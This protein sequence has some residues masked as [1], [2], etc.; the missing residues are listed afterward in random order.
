MSG[1]TAFLLI[2]ALVIV[3][4]WSTHAADQPSTPVTL[5]FVAWKADHP[6]AWEEAFARF[7]IQH[8]HISIVRELAPHSSTAYHDLLTQKLRNHDATVDLFFMDI[9]WVP[10]FAS[11]GW[12]MPLDDLFAPEEQRAFLPAAVETGRYNGQIYGVPSRIDSG[13][14]FYRTDLLAK[15]GFNPPVT[16]PELIGQATAIVQGEHAAHPALSGYSGQFK[17]YEGLVCSMMEFIGSAGGRLLST[18]LRMSL[19]S[20]PATL[21]AVGFV[22]QHIIGN[23]ASRAVLTYQEP[24]SVVPFIQGNAVFHRNWPYTWEVANDPR[25]SRVAGK[26]GV[27]PLPSM[28]D[29]TPVTALGG[30]LYAIS[31]FSRHQR[32]AWE[33][34]RFISSAPLQR[35]F[36]LAAGIAPSRRTILEDEEVL[37]A[38]PH[39]RAQLSMFPRATARPR[40]P[41]YPAISNILQRYFSRVL[42]YRDADVPAEAAKADAQINRLLELGRTID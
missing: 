5:R 29:H 34:I 32:E 9:V 27:V 11:A 39:F 2:L 41:L 28:A 42:A 20:S 4:G 18:D 36:A 30:W 17:Q 22:R 23:V 7:S 35:H 26:V 33:F 40:T 15:Y 38:N 37:R 13:M 24:E 8:P 6:Q 21:S 31:P 10:E 3:G 14:L 12:V 1:R 19:L 25:R 16:W